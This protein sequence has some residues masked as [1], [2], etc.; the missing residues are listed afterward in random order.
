M[1]ALAVV[2]AAGLVAVVAVVGLVAVAAVVGLFGRIPSRIAAPAFIS[3][4]NSAK[5]SLRVQAFQKT[6]EREK[7][8]LAGLVRNFS[9]P[10]SNSGAMNRVRPPSR[11]IV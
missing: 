8:S 11:M 1:S 10:A 9:A 4:V 7:I 5:G 2:A 6:I 3:L